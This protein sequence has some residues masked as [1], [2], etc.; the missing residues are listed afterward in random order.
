MSAN[1][2]AAL[3]E[4]QAAPVKASAAS[5]AP[6]AQKSLVGGAKKTD[7]PKGTTASFLHHSY[8]TIYHLDSPRMLVFA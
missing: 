7:A 1:M 2:F 5:S 3:S 8:L 4:D 6:Q